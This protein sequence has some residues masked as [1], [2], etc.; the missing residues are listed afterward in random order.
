MFVDRYSYFESYPIV[1]GPMGYGWKLGVS[2]LPFASLLVGA[3]F[4]Y[5]V[6]C[7]WNKYV[8]PLDLPA[9]RSCHVKVLFRAE[10]PKRE[11]RFATR[12][13]IAH[14]HGCSHCLPGMW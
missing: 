6:Y 5:G 14:V 13:E 8:L 2:N 3:I 4:S 10:V 12:G 11:R 9:R 1:Y 7:L